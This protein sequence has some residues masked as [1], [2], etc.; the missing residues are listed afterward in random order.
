MN[1]NSPKFVLLCCVLPAIGFACHAAATVLDDLD[2][3]RSYHSARISSYDR[4]GGNADGGQGNGI[5]PGETRTIA[6]IK[7]PGRIVH[8]WV[9]MGSFRDAILRMYWDDEN[10]PSVEVPMG[11]FF[12]LGHGRNY[13][14]ESLP[15]AIGNDA[16]LNCFFPMP[17]TKS[18]RITVE[19][20]GTANIG[21]L[22]YYVDY[23][24]FDAPMADR[25]CFHAQYRQEKP[26][27]TPDNYT[28]LKATGRG[29]Y[30]G[31]FMFV[32]Q[33]EPGWFGEGDDM[34]YIDGAKEPALHGTGTEDYFC[35]AWGFAPKAWT[36]R[37]GVPFS[38]NANAEGSQYS[39][40][41]FH[42]EDAVA[43]STS[44]DVTIEHGHANNR[45][46][47]YSSVA[48][49]YQTEPHADFPKLPPPAE[50]LA[51]AERAQAM[52]D[53]KRFGDY[54]KLQEEIKER[55]VSAS[56]KEGA[57]FNIGMSRALDEGGEKGVQSL[58]NF[59][60]PF[61]WWN[62][63]P[64][65]RAV[66][67]QLGGDPDV[68]YRGQVVAFRGIEDGA[69][70]VITMDGKQCLKTNRADGRP[71]IYFDVDNTILANGDKPVLLDV[72]YYNGG[73]AGDVF[74]VQYDS[75]FSDTDEDKYREVQ[76]FA[77]PGKKGWN[78]A[79][80]YLERAR[81]AGR[82]NGGADF[83]IWS[84]EDADEYISSVKVMVAKE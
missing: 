76:Q 32:R 45:S 9:T 31:V 65:A 49:W 67:K 70:K 2:S 22:Y 28:I 56:I 40:Y 84:G 75:A 43:F 29:H 73:K 78:S 61:P 66:V 5:K 58:L 33:N 1:R 17:F 27:L 63:I 71:F 54:R 50:R 4:T 13:T 83:R 30:A 68:V 47:D 44:I 37:F 72:Q 79:I 18:A 12:G 24:T 69:D 7:G 16:G 23:Q 36:A 15:L 81:F 35:H 26:V 10:Q 19:N 53:Q 46:D 55:A 77:K 57:E 11:E 60:G 51:T 25:L 42:L 20:V 21:S 80:V 62:W 6:E 8:I 52:L 48:Y 38:E 3:A 59:M 39:I 74:T 34:I 64:K 14:Y 82:Q 41:R